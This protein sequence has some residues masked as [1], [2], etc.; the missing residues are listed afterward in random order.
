M[1]IRLI[2][3]LWPLKAFILIT[4][5]AIAFSNVDIS[6]ERWTPA[7]CMPGRC[8]CERIRPGAVVQP[9]NAYS[10]LSFVLVGLVI[11]GNATHTQPGPSLRERFRNRKINRNLMNSSLAYPMVY[12]ISVVIIGLGSLFYHASMTWTGQ[13]FDLMGMYMQSGFMI[14]YNLARM[15]RKEGRSFAFTYVFML[16]ILGVMLAFSPIG[17]REVFGIMI[18]MALVLELY[19]LLVKRPKIQVRYFV[20]AV[21]T[22]GLAYVIWILDISGV[23]CTPES[24]FQGHAVWHLLSAAAAGFVYLY[25]RSEENP[26]MP[27]RIKRRKNTHLTPP[28]LRP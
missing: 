22:F 26:D 6:W 17:E 5:G 28:D 25:F 15:Y 1:F 4:L 10:N 16:A 21:A 2:K 3:I 12:G 8:F 14:V 23:L 13:W 18:A 24:W 19:I 9:V 11:M 27:V 7:P 20:A